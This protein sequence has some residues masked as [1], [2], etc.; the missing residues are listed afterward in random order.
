MKRPKVWSN[1]PNTRWSLPNRSKVTW[2]LAEELH[3]LCF[4][5]TYIH[6]SDMWTYSL[7]IIPEQWKKEVSSNRSVTV[8]GGLS[9]RLCGTLNQVKLAKSSELSLHLNTKRQMNMY[10]RFKY[11]TEP[12]RLALDSL[13]HYLSPVRRVVTSVWSQIRA[14]SSAYWWIDPFCDWLREFLCCQ[15]ED[16]IHQNI[17]ECT[18]ASNQNRSN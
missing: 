7:V 9:W 6:I 3:I 18:Y 12:F 14:G 2:G 15:S 13:F 17:N 5:C 4:V 1:L 8:W 16:L 11:L 10:V